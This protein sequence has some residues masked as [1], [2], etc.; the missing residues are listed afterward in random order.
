MRRCPPASPSNAVSQASER[1]RRLA[2]V[3][4]KVHDLSAA[5]HGPQRLDAFERMFSRGEV[6]RAP[7]QRAS[8]C[9]AKLP[10]PRSALKGNYYVFHRVF[11]IRLVIDAC[12]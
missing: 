10:G 7:A 8:V 4:M 11:V 12:R 1:E 3:A 5:R 6:T 9:R 2:R